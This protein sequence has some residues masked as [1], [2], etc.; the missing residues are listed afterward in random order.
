MKYSEFETVLTLVHT[1]YARQTM[2][3]F[4]YFWGTL[5][6]PVN[7]DFVDQ[8]KEKDR[9]NRL[10]YNH[11]KNAYDKLIEGVYEFWSWADFSNRRRFCEV[12]KMEKV[13]GSI[14]SN[15]TP[16]SVTTEQDIMKHCNMVSVTLKDRDISRLVDLF[17]YYNKW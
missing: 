15:G 16:E 17:K 8:W 14:V 3:R 7:M 5:D 2:N 6:K 13:Y 9:S 4:L 10:E 11:A 1:F 12:L